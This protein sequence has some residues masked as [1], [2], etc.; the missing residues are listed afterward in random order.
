MEKRTRS[1]N[2]S[3][4]GQYAFCPR[5]WWLATMEGVTPT[6]PAALRR[7]T[8]AHRRHGRRVW[9]AAL[10]RTAGWVVLGLAALA[11]IRALW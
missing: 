3:E 9:I 7:G 1:I 4:V 2:A 5:A 11:L 8:R 6:D 10:L